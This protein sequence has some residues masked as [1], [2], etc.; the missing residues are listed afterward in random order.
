MKEYMD[1]HPGGDQIQQV[2]GRDASKYFPRRPVGRLPNV[3]I[4]SDI[5]LSTTPVCDEFDDLDELMKTHCHTS[6][7]GYSGLEKSFG[8]Y[9]R[10][11]L[12]H[13]KVNLQNRPDTDWIMIYN[14]IYNV[15]RYIEGLRD[16]V[17]D[18]I[19]TKSEN[20]YLSKDLTRLVINKRGQD[21]TKVYEALF[22]ND[23]QLSCLD[24]LFYIGVLDEKD[25]ILCRALNIAMYSVMILI[26]AVLGIQCI[27]SLVYLV[28]LRRT[29][30]RDDTR[31]KIIVMVPCY[32][33]GDKELRK[34]INSVMDTTY[35][36]DNKVSEF[37]FSRI[38][39]ALLQ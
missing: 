12:A 28:R 26:A 36:D 30:T 21:A 8:N 29:I 11:T 13:R 6:S 32:N 33:E 17:T 34:T 37:Y 22:S 24:D 2:I 10:G 23:I 9:E 16:E 27:C 7:V 39:Y 19:D 3:C 20:A 35:P 15:T 38:E 31:S 14:R 1:V 25:H 4:N 5:E 18:E